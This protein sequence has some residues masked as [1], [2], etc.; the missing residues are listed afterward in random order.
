MEKSIKILVIGALAL[1][2]AT[3]ASQNNQAKMI[4][5]TRQGQQR[6]GRPGGPPKFSQ[7]LSLMDENKDGK[8]AKNELQGPIVNDFSRIDENNDGFITQIEFDNAPRTE[9]NGPT[10]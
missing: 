2:M 10:P 4:S 9:R 6:G 1:M 3:C 5:P 7:L 8:L